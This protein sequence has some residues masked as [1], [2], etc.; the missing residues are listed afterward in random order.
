MTVEKATWPARLPLQLAGMGGVATVELAVAVAGAGGLGMVPWFVG[1]DA[2]AHVGVT[3]LGPFTTA[4]DAVAL[5]GCGAIDRDI[6]IG[7][8]TVHGQ[9]A[10][11]HG[12]VTGVRVVAIKRPGAGAKL[13]HIAGSDDQ[14]AEG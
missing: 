11:G 9:R 2:P 10:G 14:T 3:L 8:R 7:L 6:T 12:G 4:D 1:D 13:E 5:E